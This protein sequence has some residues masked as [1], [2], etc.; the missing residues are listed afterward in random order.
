MYY[1]NGPATPHTPT[2]PFAAGHFS[3]PPSHHQQQHYNPADALVNSLLARSSAISPAKLWTFLR[4]IQ[5]SRD[6][7]DLANFADGVLVA[8]IIRQ[9]AP[10]LVTSVELQHL[11]NELALGHDDR[12][13]WHRLSLTAFAQL[14]IDLTDGV[15][16]AFERG[17][18]RIIV[19]FIIVL[20]EQLDQYKRIQ[21]AFN[22]HTRLLI[23]DNF[24]ALTTPRT[25][26]GAP[27]AAECKRPWVY[28]K[29]VIRLS[30]VDYQTT[31]RDAQ[32]FLYPILVRPENIHVPVH[33][34][35]GKMMY[36]IYVV[37]DEQV[38]PLH[39][40][41]LHSGNTLLSRRVEIKVVPL[42]ELMAVMYSRGMAA[43][44]AGAAGQGQNQQQQPRLMDDAEW[45]LEDS[46]DRLIKLC[47]TAKNCF[48]CKTPERPFEHALSY[49]SMVPWTQGVRISAIEMQRLYELACGACTALL[50]FLNHDSFRDK[51]T[52]DLLYRLIEASLELPFSEEQLHFIRSIQDAHVS[53]PEEFLRR[54]LSQRDI[55]PTFSSSSSSP[56]PVD[57]VSSAP[58]TT[59]AIPTPPR[60]VNEP[61]LAALGS[62][63]N[64]GLDLY[65]RRMKQHQSSHGGHTGL[66]LTQQQH[67]HPQHH[68]QSGARSGLSISVLPGSSSIKPAIHSAFAAMTPPY[69]TR[70]PSPS[71]A[72][73]SGGLV[74]D[75]AFYHHAHSYSSG[76]G[77]MSAGLPPAPLSA[78]P[79]RTSFFS[80][81]TPR[82]PDSPTS[83]VGTGVG[84]EGFGSFGGIAA[85]SPMAVDDRFEGVAPE[86]ILGRGLWEAL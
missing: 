83:S 33:L 49:L 79:T 76:S 35:T 39:V 69:T 32:R 63:T 2:T 61:L 75:S 42:D 31:K 53:G 60:A 15:V 3:L 74:R 16:R 20:F 41:D 27:F 9:Y 45:I 25:F 77:F 58:T 80:L 24:D 73:G 85:G 62:R 5:L 7:N 19:D 81:A 59:M 51:F 55:A 38:L 1:G 46:K 28:G 23:S 82:Y 47:S 36:T 14:C 86:S 64:G 68:S 72:A 84:S 26:R 67:Q 52:V 78:Q 4:K 43:A 57:P 18:E 70:S 71:D 22:S 56:T 54:I 8:E 34:S 17:D 44:G 21:K 12:P 11:A 10:L 48:N 66:T 65:S 37:F 30:N 29:T 40:V 50:T 13:V 6:V